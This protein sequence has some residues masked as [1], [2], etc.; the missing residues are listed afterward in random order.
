MVVHTDVEDV[1]RVRH[2]KRLYN[3]GKTVKLKGGW[4][5]FGNFEVMQVI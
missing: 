3:N 4:R 5:R 1:W 2:K